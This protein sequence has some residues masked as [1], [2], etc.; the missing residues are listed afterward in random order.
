VIRD[1]EVTSAECGETVTFSMLSAGTPVELDLLAFGEDGETPILGG[2]CSARAAYG[3]TVSVTCGEL[4]AE[5]SIEL[6]LQLIAD[7]LGATACG[8]LAKLSV[9]LDGDAQAPIEVSR[10]DP[11][12]KGSVRFDSVAAGEHGLSVS[13]ERGG[14][15]LSASCSAEVQPGLVARPSCD[16][17]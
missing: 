14:E 4:G 9:T 2:H 16:A 13:V 8:E 17:G 5:G 10:L 6:P 1:G 12:C 15:A 7:A 11:S 3:A